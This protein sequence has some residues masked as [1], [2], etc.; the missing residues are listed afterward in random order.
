MISALKRFAITSLALLWLSAF[1]NASAE[2]AP[3]DERSQRLLQ[4]V[5]NSGLIFMEAKLIDHGKTGPKVCRSILVKVESDTGVSHTLR[6]QS[7]PRLFGR[8][9]GDHTYGTGNVLVAGLYTVQSV[10][11]EDDVR[12]KG[13]FAQFT[14]RAGQ[15]LNLGCLTIV[16]ELG[17]LK[18]FGPS[19]NKGDW[20]TEDL[21]PRAVASLTKSAPATFAKAK[22]QYMTPI[23]KT[24]KP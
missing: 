6:T 23:R 18:L 16:Y 11:C 8:E 10:E 19:D 9:V 7:S 22:R 15:V 5:P 24:S 13:P 17:P 14:V 4:A 3:G 21:S 20:K 2:P 1:N 12:L